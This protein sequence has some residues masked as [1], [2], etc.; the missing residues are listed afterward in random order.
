VGRP[1]RVIIAHRL[2]T[3]KRRRRPDVQGFSGERAS[4]PYT[5]RSMPIDLAALTLELLEYKMDDLRNRRPVRGG[6]DSLWELRR[7]LDELRPR[8]DPGQVERLERL[9]RELGRRESA[10]VDESAVRSAPDFDDLLVAGDAPAA[11]PAPG[12]LEALDLDLG[13]A[14]TADDDAPLATEDRPVTPQQKAEQA[15]LQ[16]LAQRVFGREIERFAE[17]VAAG[18]RAERERV[19]ARL[20]YATMRNFELYRDSEAFVH[21]ANLRSFT[22]QQ[23]IPQRMDP[24]VSLSDVDSLVVIARDVIDAVRTLRDREPAPRIPRSGSL[25]HLRGMALAVARDPYAG[26]RAATSPPGPSASDLR[27]A[28]ADLARQRLPDWQ[29]QARRQDLEARLR[30]RQELERSQASMLRRD[31]SRFTAHVEAFFA[32]LEQLLPRSVGGSAE[33]PQLSGGVLFAVTPALRRSELSPESTELTLRAAGAVRLPFAGRDLVV[34]VHGEERHLYIGS[35]EIPLDAD[36]T[37]RIG[38]DEFETFV[39]GTYLHVR[40]RASGGSLAARVAAAA[41]TLHVLAGERRDERLAVLRMIAPGA[42]GTP[43]ALVGEALRRAAQIVSKAPDTRGALAKL[44]HGAAR[45]VGVEL[46]AD[47]LASFVARAQLAIGGSAERLDDALLMLS[48]SDPAAEPPQLVPFPGDPVDVAVGGRTVT[49]RRYGIR[50]A[51]HL[52]AMLP[53]QVIGSFREQLVERMG[54]GTFVCVHGE[55][56]LV[57]GFLPSIAI[58]S[59][60]DV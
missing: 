5:R 59:R 15:A 26:K 51:D 44:M 49:I 13:G 43:S 18:W 52:V 11:P 46:D 6:T 25:N 34:T 42:P 41:A 36:R 24:L 9:N 17:G 32:R 12:S 57:V 53:G 37:V 14:G 56:Q 50:G 4:A 23:P 3:V 31:Q 16:R 8:L 20:L 1:S 47:W 54:A 28:L 48:E 19:T 55:Q 33:E 30:E 58:P 10:L 2:G 39:E 60:H 35:T 29:R 45:A 22:V 7:E 38:E 27:S 21:D 40:L